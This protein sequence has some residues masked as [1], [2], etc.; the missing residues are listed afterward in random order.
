MNFYQKLKNLDFFESL[1]HGSVYFISFIVV[2][3]ISFVSLPIITKYLS[4]ADY[5]ITEVFLQSSRIFGIIFSL[6]IYAG[7]M[8]YL[9]EP[10]IDKDELTQFA[11]TLICLSFSAFALIIL[12][13]RT[14]FATLLNI[15]VFLIYPL[16]VYVIFNNIIGALFIAITNASNKSILY[17]VWNVT[18]N[19]VKVILIILFLV[20]WKAD[21][22]GRIYAEVISTTIIIFISIVLFFPYVFH[23]KLKVNYSK[24]LLVYSAGLIPI[25]V[26]GFL[27]TYL[28]TLII[29]KIKGS[30]DAGLYSYAYKISI[31]YTGMSNAFYM[32]VRPKFYH[33]V[34]SNNHK[35]LYKEQLSYLKLITFFITGFLFFAKDLG[36]LLATNNLFQAGLF[37]LPIILIG[38][39]LNDLTELYNFYINYEKKNKLFV[40]TFIFTTIINFALNVIF[41]P[42][43]GYLASAYIT[44]I[45][46][47]ILFAG[48]YFIVKKYINIESLPLKIPLLYFVI[49]VIVALSLFCMNQLNLSYPQSFILR[50]LM[51]ILLSLY[52]WRNILTNF[53]LSK[54]K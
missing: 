26:S 54:N 49:T 15:P 8:R 18:I 44:L 42:L 2:Q 33:L 35:A 25:A 19:L 41:V 24:E 50:S 23:F 29:N 9:F 52:F 36:R 5:G 14:Y 10:N 11:F 6:N 39:Y 46:Y 53:L 30:N 20:F 48:T 21:F 31:I 28:D 4:P 22:Q 7:L 13:F 37:I 27:L 43:Y 34:N 47:V 12:I 45:S 38:N 1:K 51:F 16:L 32:S 40:F 3:L 17:A